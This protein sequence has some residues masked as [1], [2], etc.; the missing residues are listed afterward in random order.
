MPL[1]FTQEDFLVT[2]C[3]CCRIHTFLC[4]DASLIL[5]FHKNQSIQAHVW[6][7]EGIRNGIRL[8]Q[9]VN[10]YFN[11]NQI[12]LYYFSA[13]PVA[14]LFYCH[15]LIIAK[16]LFK[17]FSKMCTVCEIKSL[18]YQQYDFTSDHGLPGEQP[19]EKFQNCPF[20]VSN[21]GHG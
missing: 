14:N 16:N 18:V 15:K 11:M 6:M 12:N 5:D 8:K 17:F 7:C 3:S 13:S 21:R 20:H 4:H 19:W 2:Y 1:A 10:L 9:Q